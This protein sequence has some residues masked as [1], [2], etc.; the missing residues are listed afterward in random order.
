MFRPTAF[1]D[2]AR[3]TVGSWVNLTAFTPNLSAFNIYLGDIAHNV[4]YPQ[5]FV[6]DIDKTIG[7]GP[8]SRTFSISKVGASTKPPTWNN[9]SD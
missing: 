9:W 4:G 8:S 6:S 1:P 3:G 2:F 7:S 5:S